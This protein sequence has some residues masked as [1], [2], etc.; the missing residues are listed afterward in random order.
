MFMT[1]LL[2]A[3]SRRALLLSGVA[4]GAATL[5]PGVMTTAAADASTDEVRPFQFEFSDQALADLRRRILATRW[6]E[7]ETVSDRSQGVQSETM[8]ALAA[9]WAG[10]Y[11]WRRGEARLKG[12]PHFI[13]NIDGLD[14]HF[15]HVRSKH[16]DA[17]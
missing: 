8:R 1:S 17:L 15:I 9:Y 13:T 7:R 11:D 2:H 16:P 4:A 10:D 5:L 6:P 3:P 14:I 12:L